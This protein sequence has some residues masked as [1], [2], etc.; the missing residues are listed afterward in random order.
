M[1]RIDPEVIDWLRDKKRGEIIDVR[2]VSGGSFHQTL[3]IMTD[4]H[5]QF[6]LKQNLHAPADM[7]YREVDGLETLQKVNGPFVPF[8]FHVGMGFLLLEDMQPGPP[9]ANFWQIYGRQMG[10]MHRH[11][12]N[13]FGYHIDN[14]IGRS[15]QFNNHH[16]SGF[17]FY[18]LRRLIP[19][20]VWARN[21]SLIEARDVKHLDRFM[22]R[23]PEL[24]PRQQASLLHGDLWSGNLITDQGG[25]PVLIDPAVYY[26]WAEADL[27]MAEL[28]GSYPDEFYQAYQEVNPLVKGYRSRFPLYNLYHLLNHL[29][30]FGRS[31][32][33]QIRDILSI[34]ADR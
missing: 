19:Q 26:G 10:R 12:Q 29:N 31:Y 20:I 28:F 34:F 6:I 27:A 7:F 23:L 3:R 21:Q 4:N 30:L 14:Y 25:M 24:F 2:L 32:L 18:R 9:C 33:A 16:I 11:T 15:P 8:V 22:F 5:H 13:Y 17:N 1:A